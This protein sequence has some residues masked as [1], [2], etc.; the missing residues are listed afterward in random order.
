MTFKRDLSSEIRAFHYRSIKQNIDRLHLC[1]YS[2]V[3]IVAGQVCAS[4]CYTLLSDKET[5]RNMRYKLFSFG[6]ENHL[7]R[8]EYLTDKRFFIM[9]NFRNERKILGML[10]IFVIL[11]KCIVWTMKENADAHSGCAILYSIFFNISL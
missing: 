4:S 8:N 1:A 3:H 5:R 9:L 7:S 6:K 11:E 10:Q 2:P